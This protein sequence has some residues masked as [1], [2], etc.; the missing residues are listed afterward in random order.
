[1]FEIE[2]G[3]Q[4]TRQRDRSWFQDD[5]SHHVKSTGCQV[6]R[7][8]HGKERGRRPVGKAVRES[9]ATSGHPKSAEEHLPHPTGELILPSTFDALVTAG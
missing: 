8:G 7:H 1:M 3:E 9:R 4:E 5:V 6:R 2:I